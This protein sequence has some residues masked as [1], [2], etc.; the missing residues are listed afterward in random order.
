MNKSRNRE[1]KK[2]NMIFTT[3]LWM[4][5]CTASMIIML[6]AASRKTIVMADAGQD[7]TGI[8]PQAG[9]E[10]SADLQNQLQL[11]ENA[12]GTGV[13]TIPLEAGC[14]AENVVMENR[15]VEEQL[16]IY[17]DKADE[18]FYRD[19]VI[20]G[21]ISRVQAGFSEA[22]HGSVVIKL[23]MDE[24]LEY[25][26]TMENDVLSI[27]FSNP[28][29]QYEHIVVVDIAGGGT[30][31][32]ISSNGQQEKE[33]AL[34]VGQRLQERFAQQD[35]KLYFTRLEDVDVPVEKRVAL[36]EA[37]DADYF[38][39]I[40]VSENQEDADRYGIQS[41][42]NDNYFIPE[43]GNIELA[44]VVTKKVTIASVNRAVGLLPADEGSILQYISIPAVD[45]R[46]GFLTNANES[47]LL[48]QESYRQKL[49]EGIGNAILEVCTNGTE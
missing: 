20:G 5:V 21:D 43:F 44:D 26:S 7:Q 30:E 19:I 48:S 4:V 36:A 39:R 14:K 29:E 16:W 32:G 23:Q 25:H 28:R 8:P 34:Q 24:V 33:V 18:E 49:A 22:N 10:I 38:I 9:E 35:I 6:A 13:L 11:Q 27:A 42:Y 37:V 46:V 3:V 15:Y 47:L 1:P 40:G 2:K 17:I 45:I 12:A 41:Y 31:T